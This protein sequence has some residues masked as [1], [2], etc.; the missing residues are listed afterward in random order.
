MEA[1]QLTNEEIKQVIE[2]ID[3]ENGLLMDELHR[4]EIRERFISNNVE[5]K[6]LLSLYK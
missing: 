6:L 5:R 2:R 1:S 4:P 3:L